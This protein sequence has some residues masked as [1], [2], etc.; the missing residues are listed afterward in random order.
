MGHFAVAAVELTHGTSTSQ[1]VLLVDIRYSSLEQLFGGITT[2]RGGYF[3]MISGNGEIL[4]HPQ[5][6]LL[7]S[8]WVQENKGRA[9]GYS[10]GNHEEIFAGKKRMATVKTIGYTGWKV[11]GVTPENAVSLNT[12]KTR[13]FIVF[14]IALILCILALINSY[15]SSRITNPIRELEKSVGVL[16]AGQFSAPVYIGGSYEIRHLGKSISD[17]AGQIRLLMQVLCVCMTQNESRSLTRCSR[18]SIRISSII[19]SISLSG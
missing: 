17:M 2:G 14:V 1:G 19:R 5:M 7:D 8:G 10:D 15:I 11:V 3:Y 6:Q 4:Y 12:I 18:R 13:L 16:E 9:A